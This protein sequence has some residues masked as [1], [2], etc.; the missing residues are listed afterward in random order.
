ML[1]DPTFAT[2]PNMSADGS[3]ATAEQ[4][5]DA[6]VAGVH[7]NISYE[8]LASYSD[9]LLRDY[10]IDYP[11]HFLNL[12]RPTDPF[13]QGA[14]ASPLPYL[15]AVGNI[16]AGAPATYALRCGESEASVVARI[17]GQDTTLKCDGIDRLTRAF[18]GANVELPIDS[19]SGA[20]LFRLPRLVF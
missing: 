8:G 20:G 7:S 2:I 12:Y 14:G 5:R 3:P 9:A 11:L 4:I 10:Y 17:D 1:L 13:V 19:P 16:A 15:L 6:L 18:R